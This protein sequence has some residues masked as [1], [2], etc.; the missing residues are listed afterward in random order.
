M[1][2]NLIR[3]KAVRKY[4]FWGFQVELD[5]KATRD[6][7][8]ESKGWGCDCGHCR[9]FLALARKN[10]LPA[11]VMEVLNELGISP[12][13]ATYVCEMYPDG[14]GFFYQFSYRMAGNIL[15]ESGTA[16]AQEWGEVR[17]CH[18]PYPYGAPG[19]PTPHFDLEFW[20]T[21]SWVLDESP[22]G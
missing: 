4:D 3:V 8:A 21:L 5:E 2:S 15:G 10:A 18:E 17:C 9:N 19:F 6:W 20:L 1:K 13:K 22:N 11:P 7:Y 12:E 16:D 14:T